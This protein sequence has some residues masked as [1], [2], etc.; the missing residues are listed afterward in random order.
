VA[1]DLLSSQHNNTTQRNKKLASWQRRAP[2]VE[3]NSGKKQ[4]GLAQACNPA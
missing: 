4:L 2:E 3:K 1:A